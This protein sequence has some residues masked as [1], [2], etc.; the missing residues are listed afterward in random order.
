MVQLRSVANPP[1]SALEAAAS[2][3]A[4]TPGSPGTAPGEESRSALHLVARGRSGALERRRSVLGLESVLGQDDRV[5]ILDTELPPWRMICALEMRGPSGAGA[6][7]TGWLVG[8]RTILTAGHCVHSGRFYGGWARE[9]TASP[10]R[11]GASLPYGTIT[12]TRFASLDVWVEREDPDFDIGCIHLDEPIG[13]RLGWFALGAL[14]PSDLEGYLVNVSGYPADRGAGAEQYHHRNR[15]LRVAE[16]RL[17]YDVDTYGGQSGAPV[18]IH[19]SAAAPPLVVGIHAYGASGT[20]PVFNIEANSA[21]RMIPEVLDR[22]S[23]WVKEDGGWP[24]T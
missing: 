20:P 18:W 15:I 14:P 5:R 11:N 3:R 23:A 22:I 24:A 16:R 7:G 13:E 19:E 6:I 4:T 2:P 17:F 8:P 9:I 1:P 21:P 10:G 12:S